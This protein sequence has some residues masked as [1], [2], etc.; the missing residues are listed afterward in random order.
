MLFIM[1]ITFTSLLY[2]AQAFYAQGNI[3]LLVINLI[4]II[5]IIWMV[6][7]GILLVRKKFTNS[8]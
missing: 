6:I 2:K 4:M 1:V 3:L 8:K 7:E 5:L